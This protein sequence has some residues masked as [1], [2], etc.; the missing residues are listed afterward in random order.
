MDTFFI[1]SIVFLLIMLLGV[2]FWLARVIIS[3]QNLRNEY[4]LL[5]HQNTSLQESLTQAQNLST[6][7]SSLQAELHTANA[8]LQERNVLLE[9]IQSEHKAQLEER[10]QKYATM[11]H[12][13]EEKYTFNLATFKSEL[14]SNLKAQNMALLNQNKLMLNEDS[15]K[16]LDEIFSPIKKSVEEYEK[17]LIKNESTIQA[18]IKNMFEY[19][20]SIGKDADRLAR[21]LKGDKKVRGNFA[22]MQLQNILESSG[23]IQ[24]EQYEL[25]AHF[26]DEGKSYY[27]D[28]IVHIDSQRSIIIDAKFSLPN[29]FS[30]DSNDSIYDD[31][32]CQ[33]IAQNLK[34]RIDELAK[35]P[36][37][38]VENAYEFVLLFIP[39]NNI[40]DLAL[41]FDS[42]IYQYAYSK[43]IYLTTPHTLFMALKTIQISWKQ[44]NSEEKV[45]KAFEDIGKFYDKFVGVCEV[46]DKIKANFQT[47]EGNLTLMD[48]RL[49]S[50]K[51]NL[52][53]K[54][55]DIKRLGAKTQKSLDAKYLTQD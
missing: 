42:G 21:I 31:M 28:A 45:K 40:L 25:Q 22:E 8:L 43:K 10:E 23:L 17:T 19:S 32:I 2:V 9:R 34:S 15:K 38:K 30:L 50:G 20:Q 29:E 48:Q 24:G 26:K 18:E 27:P 35:K 12:S 49:I 54:F 44:A 16:I 6:Q 11:L 1:I 53:S 47:L 14:E 4:T 36:Y 46:F 39:Y 51:G 3:R 7:H 33:Q 13:L 55:E 52:A 41:R 5:A 37:T